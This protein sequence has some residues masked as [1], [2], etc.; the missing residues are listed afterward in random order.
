MNIFFSCVRAPGGESRAGPEERRPFRGH[1]RPPFVGDGRFAALGG[2][3]RASKPP[4]L[5]RAV[6][7]AGASRSQ[8]RQV[9]SPHSE[10]RSCEPPAKQA[11]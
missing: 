5:F 1:L 8:E 2:P 10:L 4:S 3:L 11:S 7:C 9:R 6:P